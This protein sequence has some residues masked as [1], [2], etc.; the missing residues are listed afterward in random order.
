MIP[1]QINIIIVDDN[2][3]AITKLQND[4]QSLYGDANIVGGYTS[5]SEARANIIRVQPD[6]VFLDVEMPQMSGIEFLESIRS[7]LA[8]NVQV[9]FYT[10]HNKYILDALRASAF[11]FLM[12][13]YLRYLRE[14]LDIVINRTRGNIA[15]HL[16]NDSSLPKGDKRIAMH[17]SSGLIFLMLEELV[18]FT[19]CAEDRHWSVTLSSGS[20]HRLRSSIR[21][22]DIL[23]ISSVFINV[24]QNAIVNINHISTI[25]SRTFKCTLRPPLDHI[26]L[27]SSRRN[28]VKL[29][30]CLKEI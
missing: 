28:Y 3:G 25:E 21:T 12:K 17:T 6:L 20:I 29:R 26:E 5:L 30:D 23:A 18:L 11:D 4:L 10:A 8:P 19:F 7:E 24:N 16:V 22:K 27:Y 15:K 1:H 9:V 13:P 2:Q 14:E